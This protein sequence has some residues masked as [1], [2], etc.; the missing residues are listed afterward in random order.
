MFRRIMGA[1]GVGGASARDTRADARPAPPRP[2]FGGQ[3]DDVVSLGRA[4][5]PCH[6]I[7]R[8]LGITSAQ[9]FDW[10]ITTDQGL[11]TLVESGL[12]GFFALERLGRG[13]SGM[14]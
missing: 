6:Q 8:V 13:T 5:Q 4:C 11:V 7:R 10:L 1:T 14:V 12:D 2:P 3:Y 9:V